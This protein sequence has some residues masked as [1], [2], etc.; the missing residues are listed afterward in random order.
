MKILVF[1]NATEIVFIVRG[2]AG[3]RAAL[4][5]ELG[6]SHHESML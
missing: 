5:P 2:Q 1:F 3:A 6:S 4:Q